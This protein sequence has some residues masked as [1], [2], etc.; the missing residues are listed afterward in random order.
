MSTPAARRPP[1]R[2]R[3]TWVYFYAADGELVEVLGWRDE[4]QRLTVIE[5]MEEDPAYDAPKVFI[6]TEFFT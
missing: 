5:M 6:R 2:R 1:K 3:R 4:V